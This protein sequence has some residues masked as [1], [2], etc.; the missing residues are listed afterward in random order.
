MEQNFKVLNATKSGP[1]YFE[2]AFTISQN[3]TGMQLN[4]ATWT[5]LEKRK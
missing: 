1:V 2:I 3:L 4:A 5:Q